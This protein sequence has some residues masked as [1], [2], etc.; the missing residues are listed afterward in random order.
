MEL[1]L[2][3]MVRSF[4]GEL[5]VQ[6]KVEGY[7]PPRN[8]VIAVKPVGYSGVSWVGLSDGSDNPNPVT[9]DNPTRFW[10]EAPKVL[11]QILRE[12]GGIG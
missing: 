12:K 10:I 6:R 1:E 11:C 4:L 9:P 2:A 7:T 5:H 8:V 3:T